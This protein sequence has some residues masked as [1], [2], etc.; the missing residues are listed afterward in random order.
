MSFIWCVRH[1]ESESNA[2]LP[3]ANHSSAPLTERG[4]REARA[5]ANVLPVAPD[6]VVTSS[7]LRAVQTAAPLIERFAPVTCEQWA[8][9]EFAC[10]SSATYDGTTASA[11]RP[12]VDAYWER[13]DPHYCDGPGAESFVQLVGRVRVFLRA[14]SQRPEQ[15]IVVFTHGDFLRTLV[16]YLLTGP[17]TID[18][19][20]MRQCGDLFNALSIPNVAIV[21]LHRSM[22][23]RLWLGSIMTAHCTPSRIAAHPDAGARRPGMIFVD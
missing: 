3:T 1:G 10:L 9:Q 15:H 2:G 4:H 5:V 19:A 16:W 14:L 12:V 8:I 13:C 18:R 21:P 20:Q 7:Y 17:A 22:V 6:L 23:D 11:R